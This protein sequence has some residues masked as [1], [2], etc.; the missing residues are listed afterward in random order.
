M[1]YEDASMLV[2]SKWHNV[3][4]LLSKN[5]IYASKK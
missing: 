1:T 5:L 4:S 2:H 3:F